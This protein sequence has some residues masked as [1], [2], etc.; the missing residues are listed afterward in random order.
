MR[1]RIIVF[2][3]HQL[4]L[5]HND[6]YGELV[7]SQPLA[8]WVSLT[9]LIQ[10]LR[11]RFIAIAMNA[12][13]LIKLQATRSP[14]LPAGSVLLSSALAWTI[15]AVPPPVKTECGSSPMVTFGAI[16]VPLALPLAS[17]VKFGMSPA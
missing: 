8:S 4:G 11:Y 3:P 2:G 13:F 14:A 1:K 10:F 15:S 16:T 9:K 7:I 12:Y 17:T 5:Q 6:S